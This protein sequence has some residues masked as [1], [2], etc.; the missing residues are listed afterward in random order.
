MMFVAV[1]G[2]TV[3]PYLFFWQASEEAE[4]DLIEKKIKEIGGEPKPIVTR[5][6]IRLSFKKWVI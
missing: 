4:E 3:S 6:E 5:R 2:T 1:F